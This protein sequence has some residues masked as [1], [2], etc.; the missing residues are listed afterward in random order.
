MAAASVGP[1]TRPLLLF[2]GLGQ[3]GQALCAAAAAKPSAGHGLTFNMVDPPYGEQA[4]LGEVMIAPKGA[5]LATEVA[6]IRKSPLLQEPVSLGRLI[7][8]LGY[9]ASTVVPSAGDTNRLEVCLL[10]TSPSPRD[11]G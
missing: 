4:D 11:R 9:F 1:E 10:Y 3:A 7:G 5:G 2:Y 6:S 8:A